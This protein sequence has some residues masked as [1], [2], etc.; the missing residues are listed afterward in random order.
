MI[1]QGQTDVFFQYNLLDKPSY[2]CDRDRNRSAYYTIGS[3]LNN[4]YYRALIYILENTE[5]RPLPKLFLLGILRKIL[6][7]TNKND[8]D[9]LEKILTL[10][11]EFDPNISINVCAKIRK[12]LYITSEETIQKRRRQGEQIQYIKKQ[13]SIDKLKSILFSYEWRDGSINVLL[14]YSVSQ[15]E[16]DSNRNIFTSE[17]KILKKLKKLHEKCEEILKVCET[18]PNNQ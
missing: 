7:T 9:K 6:Y 17:R 4:E 1:I 5:P 2:M 8:L 14:P 11:L 3:L 12:L 15:Y 13:Q 18:R 16:N 10:S